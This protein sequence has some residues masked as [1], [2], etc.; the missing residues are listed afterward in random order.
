[1][2]STH[3]AWLESASGKSRSQSQGFLR[4]PGPGR[5]IWGAPSYPPPALY[6]PGHAEDEAARLQARLNKVENQLDRFRAMEFWDRVMQEI[7][8]IIPAGGALTPAEILPELRG[9]TIR[10]ATLHKEPL[11]LATLKKKMD[12]RV[13]HNRYFEPRDEGRY[14]RK[15]G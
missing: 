5:G 6:R 7:F 14:A 9:V 2:R 10:G 8:E 11:N 15:V 13:S 3:P 1:M 4:R 12:V